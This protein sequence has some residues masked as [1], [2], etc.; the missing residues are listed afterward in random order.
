M[1][2]NSLWQQAVITLVSSRKKFFVL[3]WSNGKF[4]QGEADKRK[5]AASASNHQ[6]LF[7]GFFLLIQ[8][9]GKMNSRWT[10]DQ[11][12]SF[13]SNKEYFGSVGKEEANPWNWLD[14]IKRK[15]TPKYWSHPGEKPPAL[16]LVL[17]PVQ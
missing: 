14:N 13:V 2:K 1:L 4:H 8:W 9:L 10:M 17:Q 6:P 7:D 5:S 16:V 12:V 3:T 11:K 15:D